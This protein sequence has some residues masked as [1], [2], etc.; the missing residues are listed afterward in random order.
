M[1]LTIHTL[2]GA[3]IANQFKNPLLGWLLAFFSH[4]ILDLIPHR[5]YS[6]EDAKLGW[7]NKKFWFVAFKLLL[8]LSAGFLFII[9][10]TQ[11]KSNLLNNLMGGFFGILADG[12]SLAYYLIKNRS[13][14]KAILEIVLRGN[15]KGLGKNEKKN[16]KKPGE[17][18]EKIG[19]SYIKFCRLL[20]FNKKPP[21]LW[22]LFNQI[23][24][25]LTALLL[26]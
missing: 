14:E 3:V 13:W 7:K 8:D 23:I 17:F 12:L 4:F 1:I 21:L 15:E 11:N 10:F 24:I 16:E 22:G 25:F 18:L 26:L 5:E 6:L 2:A 20:H 19:K 9:I